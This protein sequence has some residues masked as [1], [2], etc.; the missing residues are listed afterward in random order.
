MRVV[1]TLTRHRRVIG[2]DIME[3]APIPGMHAPDFLAAKLL[4]KVLGYCRPPAG[5]SGA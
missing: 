2:F 1:R 3:H 4:N 5:S